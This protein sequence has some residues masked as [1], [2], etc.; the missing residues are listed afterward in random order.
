MNKNKTIGLEIAAAAIIAGG[1]WWLLTNRVQAAPALPPG[2]VHPGT[3]DH[4]PYPEEGGD[5]TK[6]MTNTDVE[7]TRTAWLT[8]YKVPAAYHAYWKTSVEI[9][10]DN[11]LDWDVAAQTRAD[12][13]KVW[14][15]P[16][17]C[18]PGVIAHEMSH[19]ARYWF[20]NNWYGGFV[21]EYHRTLATDPMLVMLDLENWYMNTAD[22]EAYAEIY[23]YLGPY[24]PLSMVPYYQRLLI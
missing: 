24:T 7:I 20:N 8:N 14:V 22:S 11:T 18:N 4:I 19:V 9:I 12:L 17:Y 13:R 15:C 3:L 6:T 2:Y 5:F 21:D 16:P 1:A 23:R 10:L